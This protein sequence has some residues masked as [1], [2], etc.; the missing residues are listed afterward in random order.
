MRFDIIEINN[1][2]CNMSTM[3][4][5]NMIRF[6]TEVRDWH[7]DDRQNVAL[8]PYP[9]D[10]DIP[11]EIPSISEYPSPGESVNCG[12]LKAKMGEQFSNIDRIINQQI[13]LCVKKAMES[14]V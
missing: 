6:S 3:E 7:R 1:Y 8:S 2:F 4:Y 14:A 5:D 9:A 12:K 11:S 13:K 10:D